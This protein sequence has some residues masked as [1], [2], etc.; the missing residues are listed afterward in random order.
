VHRLLEYA[1]IFALA[2]FVFSIPT[3][4]GVAIPGVGSLSR[5]IGIVAFAF[6]LLSLLDRGGIGL[7]APSLFLIVSTL[8]LAWVAASTLWSVVPSISQARAIQFA[9]LV[10][11]SW[12]V[13]QVATDDGRRNLLFQAF[14]LG[15][16]VMVGVALANSFGPNRGGYRDVAFPANSFAISAALAIPMAWS[17]VRQAHYAPIGFRILNAAYPAVAA[18]AVVLA[19][20]RGGLITAAIC[21]LVIP[22][23]S[24]H[25]GAAQRNLSL[26]LA[27]GVVALVALLSNA[28]P[29][30]ERNV[31][32]LARVDEDLGATMTGRTDI[33]AAG[34]EVFWEAPVTGTGAGTF[35]YMVNPLIGAARTA[36]NAYLDVA[37]TS[38]FIGLVLFLSLFV[39]SIAGHAVVRPLRFEPLVLWLA[40]VVSSFP[41][42]S[43]DNK[44]LW[45]ILALLASTRPILIVASTSIGPPSRVSEH[46]AVPLGASEGVVMAGKSGG[47]Q[48]PMK[49]V[50]QIGRLCRE[51][52][53]CE[54]IAPVPHSEGPHEA[55]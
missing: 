18:V 12:M 28:I 22:L 55:G 3:E 38:G 51:E 47:F 37:V 52:R 53:S 34:L 21:L 32:R 10:V 17:L 49:H 14:V 8:F 45:F 43:E 41:S 33:W 6:T 25:I 42:N 16:Y 24:R 13:H 46:A 9:Q 19:A 26:W 39:V 36:H 30:V 27:L 11:F 35:S 40:L 29:D 23:S 44:Y 48:Q 31:E 4:Q 1:A 2:A 50:A 5:M 54:R 20:S 7:R 15:C